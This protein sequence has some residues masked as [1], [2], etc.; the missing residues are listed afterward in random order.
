MKP[1]WGNPYGLKVRSIGEKEDNLFVTEFNL[2]Q[3]MEQVLGGSPWLVGRHT[4]LLQPYDETVRPSE[5]KFDCMDIW[6]HILNPPLGWMNRHHGEHAMGLVGVVKK[7]DVDK[8]GK[9]SGAFL[10]ARALIEIAKPLR[11]GVLLKMRHDAELE[12]FDLQ[13][14]KVPFY[15]LSC[16]I[17]GHSKL[18][19]DKLVM[20]CSSG[21][22]PYCGRTARNSTLLEALVFH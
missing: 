19:Y 3:D 22:L 4:L 18:D 8:D 13:Y 20:R 11:R 5:I 1:A 10:C 17:M 2:Q 21:K 9:A 6:V 7:M 12:W 15:C 16:G 14:E